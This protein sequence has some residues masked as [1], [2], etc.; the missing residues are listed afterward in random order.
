MRSRVLVAAS[1]L[2]ALHCGGLAETS[3]AFAKERACV[4]E[5][6]WISSVRQRSEGYSIVVLSDL[7][8]ITA[9]ALVSRLNS[10]P[11]ETNFTAN[12][13]MIVG[14]HLATSAE[15]LPYVLMALFDRGCLVQ[16]SRADPRYIASL[17]GGE[18]T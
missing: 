7:R 1:M 13:V 4:S 8:G 18:Q 6:A 12:H 10:D 11:P 17:L 16:W 2:L 5:K 9:E 3:P 14:A 15:L